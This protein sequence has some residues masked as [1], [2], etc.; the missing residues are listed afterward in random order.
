MN[1][2][3]SALDIA[4]ELDRRIRADGSRI[5][6]EYAAILELSTRQV[7]GATEVTCGKY[8]ETGYDPNDVLVFMKG[9][10]PFCCFFGV[11]NLMTYLQRFPAM[12]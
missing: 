2:Y 11:R 9:N 8:S 1:D 6:E 3:Q 5:S 4:I 10:K 12:G 7:F